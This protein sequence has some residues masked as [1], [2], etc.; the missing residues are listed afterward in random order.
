MTKLPLL[1]FCKVWPGEVLYPDFTLP[2]TK[3]WWK[4]QCDYFH[5]TS[6]WRVEYDAL[7]IVSIKPIITCSNGLIIKAL[8]ISN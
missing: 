3:D 1:F 7:W 2:E 6:G 4:E 8:S 5:N